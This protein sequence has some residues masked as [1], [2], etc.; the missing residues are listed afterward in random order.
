[1]HHNIDPGRGHILKKTHRGLTRP[2]KAQPVM[3]RH[4]QDRIG[5]SFLGRQRVVDALQAALDRHAGD[6][7]HRAPRSLGRL[8]HDLRHPIALGRTQRHDLASMA[9]TGQAIDAIDRG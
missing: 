7:L 8:G 6:R 4:Q 9:I 2:T 5:S 3:R 1:M